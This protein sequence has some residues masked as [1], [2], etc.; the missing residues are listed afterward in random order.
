M[1]DGTMTLQLE[2]TVEIKATAEEK[3]RL[4]LDMIKLINSSMD[5]E[6]SETDLCIYCSEDLCENHQWGCPGEAIIER[7]KKMMEIVKEE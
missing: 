2:I 7:A 1:G 6:E 3:D 4:I 5:P